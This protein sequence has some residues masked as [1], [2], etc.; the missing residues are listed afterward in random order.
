MTK[1]ESLQ[2]LKSVY[3]QMSQMS[4][5]VLF[6]FMM[7][8]SQSFRDDVES[9]RKT[10]ETLEI[11]S[12][13]S[14]NSIGFFSTTEIISGQYYQVALTNAVIGNEEIWAKAA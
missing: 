13:I 2:I 1:Q 3:E 6:D 14:Q 4:D 7:E 8:N 11:K 5:D 12:E 9:F 10:V